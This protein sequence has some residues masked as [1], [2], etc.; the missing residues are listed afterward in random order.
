MKAITTP[1]L[2]WIDEN[3]TVRRL[4]I[5]DRVFIGRV[6]QGVDEQRRIIVNSP[7]VSR[8]HA[9]ISLTGSQLEIR[10][11]SSNGTWVNDI[12]V[13]SGSSKHLTDGDV[14]RVGKTLLHIKCPGTCPIEEQNESLASYTQLANRITTVT[15]LV[16]DVRGFS[17]MSQTRSSADMYSLMKIIFERFSLIVH[18]NNGT[19]K[20][21]AGDAVFAFWD[22]NVA[23][24]KEQAVL[25]CQSALKQ[26]HSVSQ[27]KAELSP[28]DPLVSSLKLGWGITTGEVTLS[29]YGSRAADLALVGDSV[30]LAFRL[31]G[32]ANKDVPAE[33]VMCTHT[34]A[35]VRDALAVE[36]LGTISVRGRSGYEHVYGLRASRES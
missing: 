8:D 15:H 21:F 28:S 32:L 7:T 27:I 6:C 10:D 1:Y 9:A 26:A 18:E 3:G 24:R 11:M 25:A 31:S 17:S 13:D 19:I 22:H 29:H 35:L 4:E 12:R 14:I 36:D 30:N 33:V 5:L 2:E 23:P 34:A 16:A 20:D